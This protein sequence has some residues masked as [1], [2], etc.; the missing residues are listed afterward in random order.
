MRGEILV[1]GVRFV[2]IQRLVGMSAVV[3]AG[4]GH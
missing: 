3:E 1:V 2:K 4:S